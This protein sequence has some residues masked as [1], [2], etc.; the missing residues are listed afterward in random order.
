MDAFNATMAR[1]VRAEG[2][3][4]FGFNAIPP[5]QSYLKKYSSSRPTQIT[6]IFPPIPPHSRGVSRSSRTRGGMRW[7]RAALLTRARACG[8]RSRVVLAPLAFKSRGRRCRPYR[9]RHADVREATVTKEPDHRE[10]HEGNR[11]TIAQ[12]RPGVPA[13]LWFLTRVLS[14]LCTRGRGCGGH[15]AFPAPSFSRGRVMHNS[16]ALCREIAESY[17]KLE[18]R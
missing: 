11:K 12:G 18:H 16:G 7:T 14:T 15:P 4:S 6:S 10:E 9:A 5:V 8:R 3:F 13:N 2:K 1:R 17:L